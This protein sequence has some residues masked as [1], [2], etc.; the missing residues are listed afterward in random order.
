M[1]LHSCNTT[2]IE[3]VESGA[4]AEF[5]GLQK[6]VERGEWLT[7]TPVWVERPAPKEEELRKSDGNGLVARQSGERGWGSSVFNHGVDPQLRIIENLGSMTQ[8]AHT[9]NLRL[10]VGANGREIC[11]R[12]SSKGYCNRS[13]TRSHALLRGHTRELVIRFIRGSREV[14]NK[15][16]R[17]CDG[18]GEQVYHRGHCDRGGLH[19]Y[20]NLETQNGARFGDR[21]GRGRDVNNGGGGGVRGVNGSNTNFLH[22]D[23]QK[24]RGSG[25]NGREG[26][27]SA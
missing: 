21:R 18:V 12:F 13:C 23:R 8:A 19:R 6:R 4:L 16:K 9:E 24:T 14:M 2:E 20:Q 11:L 10:P 3:E 1:F 15:Y 25:H 7:S 22:Q 17:N 26:V 27:R 5:E